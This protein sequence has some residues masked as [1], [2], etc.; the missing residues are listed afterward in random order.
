MMKIKLGELPFE[1]TDRKQDNEF[2][3]F[4]TENGDVQLRI[5]TDLLS[6]N[7]G[8]ITKE[9]SESSISGLI[10]ILKRIK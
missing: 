3:L 4:E 1:F 6:K 7:Q 9:F 2:T 5:K 8:I 10:D